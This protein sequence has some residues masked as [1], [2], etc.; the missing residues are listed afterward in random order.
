MKEI[1][2]L[3]PPLELPWLTGVGEESLGNNTSVETPIDDDSNSLTNNQILYDSELEDVPCAV[4]SNQEC[5]QQ[6][7][8]DYSYL[9]VLKSDKSP[10][11]LQTVD[12]SNNFG[13]DFISFNNLSKSGQES[14]DKNDVKSIAI[15]RKQDLSSIVDQK[16]SSEVEIK[17]NKQEYVAASVLK[18][19]PNGNRRKK[20]KRY[21]KK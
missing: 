13:A 18:V 12:S 3:C 6:I 5:N 20:N 17:V 1:I 7:S 4:P 9:Y 8:V 11:I 2:T 15:K 19:T 21:Y 14:E 10:Q 16:S